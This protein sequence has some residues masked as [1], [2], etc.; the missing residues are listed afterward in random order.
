MVTLFLLIFTSLLSA[1]RE[2][3]VPSMVMVMS[4]FPAVTSSLKVSYNFV[5]A[6]TSL[7]PLAGE[8]L[9][10]SAA[11]APTGVRRAVKKEAIV[12]EGVFPGVATHAPGG[13]AAVSTPVVGN[14][15]AINKARRGI[16]KIILYCMVTKGV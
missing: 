13:T 6:F 7:S 9:I 2:V 8:R 5:L 4:P 16:Q 3:A 11:I 10:T 14:S 12:A 15:R 1:A